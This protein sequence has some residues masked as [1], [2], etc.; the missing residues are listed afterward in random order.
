MKASY[1]VLAVLACTGSAAFAQGDV[2]PDTV[3][4]FEALVAGQNEMAVDQMMAAGRISENDPARMINL[5]RAYV[6]MGRIA[7]AANLFRSAMQSPS[8]EIELA[9]G[10]VTWSRQAA[11]I[12]LQQ[13]ESRVATR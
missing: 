13:L 7:E 11:K 1:V 2:A 5:G 8:Y 4:G 3:A 10:S 12:S 9:D 6:R